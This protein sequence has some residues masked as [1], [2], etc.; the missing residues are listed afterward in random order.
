M[1]E[2]IKVERFNGVNFR[3]W[4]MQIE[5]YMYLKDLYLSLNGKTHK[6]K[7]MSNVEWEILDRKTIGAI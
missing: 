1:K 2:K 3:F 6:P 5:D 4:K 7:E